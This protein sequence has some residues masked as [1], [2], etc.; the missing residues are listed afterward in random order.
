MGMVSMSSSERH[1]ELYTLR[2]IILILM[3][4]YHAWLVWQYVNVGYMTCY[5][6][7]DIPVVSMFLGLSGISISL[8]ESKYSGPENSSKRNK[9]YSRI[10]IRLALCSA[11]ITAVTMVF[12]PKTPILFGMLHV[13]L[14]FYVFM[15]LALSKPLYAKILAAVFLIAVYILTTSMTQTGTLDYKPVI[16]NIVF[17]FIGFLVGNYTY[18]RGRKIMTLPRFRPIEIIGKASL[19]IYMFHIPPLFFLFGGSL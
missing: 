6:F 2:G 12:T 5:Y 14:V 1:N 10:C 17:L 13:I 11:A 18:A 4:I 15:W 3:I 7:V 9:S 19:W 8:M 16:P